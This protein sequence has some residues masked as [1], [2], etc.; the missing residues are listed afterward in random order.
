MVALGGGAVSYERSTPVRPSRVSFLQT[1]N[2]IK[3]KAGV[4]RIPVSY[5]RGTP[6]R[7]DA[8]PTLTVKTPPDSCQALIGQA[9]LGPLDRLYSG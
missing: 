9:R 2:I 1:R 6:L 5:A 7:E 4:F 3:N 8:V